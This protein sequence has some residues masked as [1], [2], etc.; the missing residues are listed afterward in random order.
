LT[1]EEQLLTLLLYQPSLLLL[2][3]AEFNELVWQS[4]EANR[5][6]EAMKSCYNEKTLVQNQLKFFSSVK[7]HL[8][9]PL[10][11]KID[12]W[13]FWLTE[14]WATLDQRLT[15]ELV[16]EKIA[17]LATKSYERQKTALAFAIRK[18]QEAGD[19]AQVKR[20][21][22]ELNQLTKSGKDK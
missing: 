1:N 4:T 6:A 15:E 16:H 22:S 20:L 7:N 5:I 17:Q 9:S 18:A 13:Q 8:S 10:A 19:L 14:N 3:Q 11:E 2:L 12:R 21:M